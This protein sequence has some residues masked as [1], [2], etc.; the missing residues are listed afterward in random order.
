ML[1]DVQVKIDGH[2]GFKRFSVRAGMPG[3]VSEA[4]DLRFEKKPVPAL[5]RPLSAS[6]TSS[7][8]PRAG[9]TSSA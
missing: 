1:S 3:R 6:P 9:R 5:A 2:H 4:A 7:P 8:L